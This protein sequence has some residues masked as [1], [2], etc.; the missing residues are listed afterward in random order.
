[1]TWC[2]WPHLKCTGGAKL[3]HHNQQRNLVG[4][5]WKGKVIQ[6]NTYCIERKSAKK[7]TANA[8]FQIPLHE[9]MKQVLVQIY[10]TLI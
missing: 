6:I 5:G 4:C 2:E 10:C 1:M 7:N 3:I 9:F 8:A